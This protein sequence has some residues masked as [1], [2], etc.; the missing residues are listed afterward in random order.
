MTKVCNKA[1]DCDFKLCHFKH[2]TPSGYSQKAERIL[3]K[4]KREDLDRLKAIGGQPKPNAV[5][6]PAKEEVKDEISSQLECSICMM[7]MTEPMT[8]TPC[9]HSFC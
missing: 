7:L 2:D 4:A 8:A 6:V 3:A 1:T 5:I 9:F